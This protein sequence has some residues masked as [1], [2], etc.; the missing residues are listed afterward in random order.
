MGGVSDTR[1]IAVQAVPPGRLIFTGR[2]PPNYRID[3]LAPRR[4][5]VGD[6]VVP[7]HRLIKPLGK[8]MSG[9]VW[10]A[11]TPDGRQVA[12]KIV[13]SLASA[14]GKKELG[15]LIE[16]MNL[17]HTNLCPLQGVWLKD[18]SGRLID[19]ATLRQ[20][21][22]RPDR[23]AE[24]KPIDGAPKPIDGAPEPIDDDRPL[25]ET[26]RGETDESNEPG[27]GSFFDTQMVDNPHVTTV[28][29]SSDSIPPPPDGETSQ[30][31]GGN[32]SAR[33][34]ATA[35]NHDLMQTRVF[36]TGAAPAGQTKETGAKVL[37][38]GSL[39][40]DEWRTTRF[41]EPLRASSR[42]SRR[43]EPGITVSPTGFQS[44]DAE[45]DRISIGSA[46]EV[47]KSPH[48]ELILA[49]GLGDCTLA[50]RLS[51]VRRELDIDP[52]DRTTIG[53]LTYREALRYI[54]EAAKAIDFLN[55]HDIYHRDIKP[56]NILLV[57]GSAQV[58][59][60]GLASRVDQDMQMTGQIIATPAYAPYELLDKGY[61]HRSVDQYC[62]AVT[63]FE[64]RTGRIPFDTSSQVRIL[65]AKC[66]DQV[67]L[68][69]IA[70]AEA[71]VLAPAL[72]LNVNT[73]YASCDDFIEALAGIDRVETK[74]SSVWP[75]V[76]ATAAT[77]LV[78]VGLGA[79]AIRQPVAAVPTVAA[80][81]LSAE[82]VAEA[83]QIWDQYDPQSKEVV[84]Y[85]QLGRLVGQLQK[86]SRG[87]SSGQPIDPAIVQLA[88]F[89][90]GDLLGRVDEMLQAA[91]AEQPVPPADWDRAFFLLD[92]LTR[93][94]SEGIYAGDPAAGQSMVAAIDLRRLLRHQIH[95]NAD[96][97]TPAPGSSD[98]SAL[99]DTVAN[100]IDRPDARFATPPESVWA[101]L[102]IALRHEK[103]T[104]ADAAPG[105]SHRLLQ[106]VPRQDL[107]RVRS[108]IDPQIED[109]LTSHL[110]SRYRK[111]ETR[112]MRQFDDA[113]R[114]QTIDGVALADL[115]AAYPDLMLQVRLADLS[116]AVTEGRPKAAATIVASLAELPETNDTALATQRRWLADLV[117]SGDT[118]ERRVDFA[119]RL[120]DWIQTDRQG[121][122]SLA[123]PVGVWINRYVDDLIAEEP[124]TT[125]PILRERLIE[126]EAISAAIEHPLPAAAELPWL[127]LAVSHIDI[128]NENVWIGQ[129]LETLRKTSVT[130]QDA[131]DAAI[132]LVH[133][134]D[135]CPTS[136]PR[137]RSSD[138][139]LESTGISAPRHRRPD[140]RPADRL[141]RRLGGDANR[142]TGGSIDEVGNAVAI[143]RQ[144]D[145]V[146]RW[147]AATGGR[148][149]V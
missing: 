108:V 82:A 72:S 95:H 109:A 68:T 2:P 38:A 75:W 18:A 64:I 62:L 43:S 25:F 56:Q 98:P 92:G 66:N 142:S 10:V 113:M 7:K 41:G 105:A 4:Y 12:I 73:R 117:E 107:L 51:Q 71:A 103:S 9:D 42:L 131:V 63:Y 53:G 125:V 81:N 85:D 34:E 86:A 97:T 52:A 119:K 118:I 33:R 115:Q 145:G 5:Q 30:S 54:G 49:M 44:G 121:A 140:R 143:G 88:D 87:A 128:I 84:A 58:C 83:Q 110:V 3:F 37:E 48:S 139:R 141:S 67:D 132:R 28:R 146:G 111:L 90:G 114:S 80:R 36:G 79:L 100:H 27:G 61:V 40:E 112:L 24:P 39:P 22:S 16:I 57:G 89:A 35:G 136:N 31:I 127:T 23:S 15:A 76:M 26:R 50:D 147:I 17:R 78:A 77:L 99:T 93:D 106:D 138:D 14:G 101:P 21:F 8:G 126:L 6:E 65:L 32:A 69:A 55:A 148:S 47:M 149:I 94:A 74:S 60:F 11:E 46:D 116:A 120:S 124:S 130:K 134:C 20:L 135:R 70:P 29:G 123:G 19:D 129:R 59:D 104:P 133:R 122:D 96:Q 137:G 45:A 102:A 1:G 91:A 144:L 13:R